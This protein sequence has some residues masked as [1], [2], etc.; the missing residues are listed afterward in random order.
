LA[1]ALSALLAA[2]C[3]L[4]SPLQL[5][6]TSAS[7]LATPGGVGGTVT[8]PTPAK[9]LTSPLQIVPTPTRAAIAAVN[10]TPTEAGSVSI[11][12]PQIG[13][14]EAAPP[15]PPP[16]TPE[17]TQEPLPKISLKEQGINA[18]D[19][20]NLALPRDLGFGWVQV[21]N[22]PEFPI[23]G[24]RILYRVPLNRAVSGQQ[25]DID[26]WADELE[27]L[28]RTRRGVI[29]A[30]SIGNE[31]NLSREWGGAQPDPLRYTELLA[32]GY[33]R[34]K[35]ADPD[36]LVVSSGIAPTGGDG[37]GFVDDLRYARAMFD[38]GALDVMDAYGFHPY[39]FAYAPELSPDDP[40]AKGL[41][42]RRAE[43]HRRLLEEFGAGGKKMWATEF[44][45]L[46]DSN[47]EGV[48]CDFGG[49]NWQR[50]SRKQQA[51]Y[52]VRAYDYAAKNW[53]WMGP[54]FLWNADFSRSP[55]YPDRCEQMKWYSL[56][57]EQG[58]E[59]PIAQA[60][61]RAR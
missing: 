19:Y 13:N 61:R 49:L 33:A 16:P 36:A 43:A 28:V 51:N 29:N 6:T 4:Q 37:D 59:R 30:Y 10:A 26:A 45:W 12:L 60:L 48:T 57:D 58:A 55:L 5:P 34:V 2:G 9:A 46:I 39:G 56:I 14:G 35:S 32:I 54:M 18:A 8:T 53:P 20:G 21:F 24:F 50:V 23:D 17:P 38:A 27:A 52:V 31:V 25:A 7:P 22:P 1:W 42:F 47:E 3:S 41:L 15:A 40:Q 11:A 44:G